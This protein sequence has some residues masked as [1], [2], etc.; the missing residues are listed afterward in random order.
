MNFKNKSRTNRYILTR[1][2]SP[3]EVSLFMKG[4]EKNTFE[5]RRYTCTTP[6]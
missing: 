1:N 4:T 5:D 6:R 3:N 2:I